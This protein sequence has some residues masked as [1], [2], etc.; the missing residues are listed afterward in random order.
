MGTQLFTGIASDLA[1]NGSPWSNP[2]N[3]ENL[4]ATFATVTTAATP[5]NTLQLAV[6]P[7]GGGSIPTGATVTDITIG[8][9]R[10]GT[11][12]AMGVVD[13]LIQVKV[14]GTTLPN[15]LADT[16]TVWPTSN[17]LRLYAGG[18]LGSNTTIVNPT[19][20]NVGFDILFECLPDTSETASVDWIYANVSWTTGGGGG[21]STTFAA[22]LLMGG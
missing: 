21:G 7:A 9:W 15:N 12:S 22:A 4:D 8:I 20:L 14:G 16:H 3:A 6:I 18:L 5:S 1:D 2:T 19:S 10:K 17:T 11:T 13:Q